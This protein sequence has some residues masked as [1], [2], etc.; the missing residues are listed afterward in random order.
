MAKTRKIEPIASD[1]FEPINQDNVEMFDQPSIETNDLLSAQAV[2]PIAS[3]NFEPMYK[4]LKRSIFYSFSYKI[5]ETIN[6]NSLI[7]ILKNNKLINTFEKLG[8]I[9][10]L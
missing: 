3:D 1:N 6:Y 8:I 10:R 5:N 7:K 4:I 9:I 2:E